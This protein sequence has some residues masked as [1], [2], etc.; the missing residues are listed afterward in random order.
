M[1]MISRDRRNLI[2]WNESKTHP[3]LPRALCRAACTKWSNNSQASTS[4]NIAFN[5][6]PSTGQPEVAVAGNKVFFV[7]ENANK[8]SELGNAPG[9]CVTNGTVAV[10]DYL[11][12]GTSD[13][14]L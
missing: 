12:N 3:C 9:L 4:L 1:L 7:G 11:G 5:Y 8:I 13:V 10:G 2:E 14:L 6:D